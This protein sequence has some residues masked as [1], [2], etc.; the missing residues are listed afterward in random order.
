MKS[1]LAAALALVLAALPANAVDA[2]PVAPVVNGE[3]ELAA[4]AA[5]PVMCTLFGSGYVN[6]FEPGNPFGLPWL[7]AL[8]PC[9]QGAV[10][11]AHWS[12]GAVTQYGDWD[13]DG[14]REAKVQVGVTDSVIGES[15]NFW[16]AY[17]SPH[18][19]WVAD[20]DALRFRLEGGTIPPGALVQFSLSSVP[21]SDASPFVV[22]FID[23]FL[24]LPSS[25]FADDGTGQITVNPAD[26]AF[27]AAWPGCDDEKALW[28]AAADEAARRAVLAKLRIVQHSYWNFQS[29]SA[30]V[31]LDGIELT[32][33]RSVAEALAGV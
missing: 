13:S 10:K 22:L 9:N 7:V 24:T 2:P 14:D 17:P 19:A 5:Q 1:L 3:F 15:H 18:Q 30:D 21:L 28:D 23:C 33:S 20:F 29:G 4:G 32:G 12:G 25:L 27:S 8:S 26:G 11:A 31:F 6:V 16:Q